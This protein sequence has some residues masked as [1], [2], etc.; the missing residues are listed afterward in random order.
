[1]DDRGRVAVQ[2]FLGA[3]LAA[4]LALAGGTSAQDMSFQ[5]DYIGSNALSNALENQSDADRT[6]LPEA[7]L[8]PAREAQL[9]DEF[10]RRVDGHKRQLLPEYERRVQRDGRASADGW[11]RQTAAALGR[12]DASELR[13]KY[14]E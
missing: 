2:P 4:L 5:P 13:A 6:R 7:G 12:R 11:L 10:R 14:A 3:P 8:T 9:R 1:M